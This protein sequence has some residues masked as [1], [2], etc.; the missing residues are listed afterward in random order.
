MGWG[1]VLGKVGDTLGRIPCHP[2][3]STPFSA[4]QFVA[5][6]AWETMGREL[7]ETREPLRG[8]EELKV[9]ACR[10]LREEPPGHCLT[11]RI[12]TIHSVSLNLCLLLA[13]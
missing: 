6:G 5:S 1:E 4:V 8:P 7:G 10:G 11:P 9:R 12:H 2:P 3:P 13:E